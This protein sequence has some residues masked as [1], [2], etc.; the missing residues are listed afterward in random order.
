MHLLYSYINQILTSTGLNQSLLIK[1]Y[2]PYFIKFSKNDNKN[3]SRKKEIRGL[4][5][6]PGKFY[7][8]EILV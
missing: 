5:T 6:C 2:F 1:G 7:P 4:E 8:C 3:V